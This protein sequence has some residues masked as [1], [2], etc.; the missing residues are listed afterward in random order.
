MREKHAH[1]FSLSVDRYPVV[2]RLAPTL[3]ECDD[4]D[5]FLEHGIS[6]LMLGIKGFARAESA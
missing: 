6:V 5:A 2:S 3:V 4:P 1:L